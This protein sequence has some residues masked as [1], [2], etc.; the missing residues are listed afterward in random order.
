VSIDPSPAAQHI[1]IMGVPR[2][3]AVVARA[4]KLQPHLGYL[5]TLWGPGTIPHDVEID[6]TVLPVGKIRHRLPCMV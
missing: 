2:R 1:V 5:T 4:A 6:L 3:V